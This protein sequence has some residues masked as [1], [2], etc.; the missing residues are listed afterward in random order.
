MTNHRV[1]TDEEDT[2]SQIV[3]PDQVLL[4]ENGRGLVSTHK[5]FA[6]PKIL[7]NGPCQSI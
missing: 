2:N 3:Q 7:R 5:V 1:Y 4:L 6:N